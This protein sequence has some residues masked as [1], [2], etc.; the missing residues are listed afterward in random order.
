MEGD[1]IKF[2]GFESIFEALLASRM[3][4]KATDPLFWLGRDSNGQKMREE[5]KMLDKQTKERRLS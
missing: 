2:N 1:K 3:G 5:R 4:E